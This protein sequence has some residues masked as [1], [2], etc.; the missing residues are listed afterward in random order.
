MASSDAYLSVQIPTDTAKTA[1]QPRAKSERG[2]YWWLA[3][4]LILYG[5]FKIGPI[6]AGLVI[7]TL[8]WDGV[9]PPIFVGLQ[10][11]ER[12]GMDNRLIPA[13]LNN[14]QYA[15]GTVIG[16]LILSLVLALLLHQGLRGRAFYRTA[17]FM[18]V[19]MSFV[20]VSVLWGFLYNDQFGLINNFFRAV[21]LDM[22]AQNWLGDVRIALHSLMVVDIWKWYGFHMVIFLAG[23]QSIPTELY[24]AARVDGASRWAQFWKITLPLLRPVMVINIT[25]S[26][27]GAFNVFEIPYIMTEGGP[28]NSTN[29]ISLHAYTQ[30]FEFYRFGYGAALNYAIFVL[31][32]VIALVQLRLTL[33][34]RNAEMDI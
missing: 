6:L 13:L 5:V 11:F 19:V 29:V 7:A 1:V 14:A 23:L 2:L 10:N 21:G 33:S 4:A 3:P 15:L 17:L 8:R 16:K 18:P 34:E 20:V 26:L 22:L 24:E 9:E 27:L 32:T 31:V 12:M 28:A 25:T 30:A